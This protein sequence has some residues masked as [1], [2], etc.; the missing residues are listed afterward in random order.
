MPPLIG[1]S[2]P[3]SLQ[4][5]A[6]TRLK[7]LYLHGAFNHSAAPVAEAA[8]EALRPLTALRFLAISGNCLPTLPPAVAQMSHLLVS[9]FIC[10]VAAGVGVAAQRASAPYCLPLEGGPGVWEACRLLGGWRRAGGCLHA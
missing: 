8:W 1:M 4:I 10:E 7:I 6:L 9:S 5:S 2:A 3:L